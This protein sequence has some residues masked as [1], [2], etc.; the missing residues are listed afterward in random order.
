MSIKVVYSEVNTNRFVETV[1]DIT[2]FRRSIGLMKALCHAYAN[3]MYINCLKILLT[4][5]IVN[6]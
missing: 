1:R 4:Q 2:M 6:K 3:T 5:T